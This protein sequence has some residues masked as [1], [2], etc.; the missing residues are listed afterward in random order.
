MAKG[1]CLRYAAGMVAPAYLLEQIMQL[2][3]RERL[4][5]V[6]DVVAA[7]IDARAPE[8]P[9]GTEQERAQL[10]AILTSSERDVA[11][12]RVRPIEELLRDLRAMT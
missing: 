6:E 12:G 10:E 1:A 5:L 3:E 2:P 9:A 4:R 7:S 8:A 11:A